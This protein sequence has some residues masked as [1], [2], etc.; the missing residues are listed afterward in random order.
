MST[1]SVAAEV[2]RGNRRR[3]EL[4]GQWVIQ[5][6]V[7]RQVCWTRWNAD[8]ELKVSFE[9]TGGPY[10]LARTMTLAGPWKPLARK[11][12][13]RFMAAMLPPPNPSKAGRDATLADL[14]DALDGDRIATAA[15]LP[16]NASRARKRGTP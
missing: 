2:E 3:S 7:R 9:P 10:Y 5:A 8:S 11:Q 13:D 4:V 15:D 16:E 14:R 6:K 12:L 1:L